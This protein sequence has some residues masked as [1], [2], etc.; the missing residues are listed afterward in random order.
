[1]SE[2]RPIDNAGPSCPGCNSRELVPILYGY[3]S[4]GH[5]T[6]PHA[7]RWPSEAV[8]SA[9]TILSGSAVHANDAFVSRRG[10]EAPKT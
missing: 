2:N 1:M 4:E 8:A 3:P 10:N 6:L 7:V 9:A 5:S